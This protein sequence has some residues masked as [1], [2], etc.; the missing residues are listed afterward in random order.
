MNH[1]S[2]TNKKPYEENKSVFLLLWIAKHFKFYDGNLNNGH[3]Y[4]K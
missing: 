2:Y 1:I 3:Y 4:Y